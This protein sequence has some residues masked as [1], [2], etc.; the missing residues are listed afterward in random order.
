MSPT[1]PHC[2]TLPGGPT[3]LLLEAHDEPVV[4]FQ[5]WAGVG[6]ADERDSERG[7]AH[8][9]EHMLFKGTDRRGVGELAGDVEGAGGRINA[10]T[11]FDVTVYHT[12]LPSDRA[13]VGVDV[14]CDA[15]LHSRFDADELG[16][17]IEVVLEE[18]RRSQD[19][20]G[21]VLSDALFSHTYEVHPYR[22]PILGSNDSVASFHRDQVRAFYQ[23]WYTPD[24]LTVVATGD[25]DSAQLTARVREAFA[26]VQGSGA[27][28]A[29][30]HEPAQRKLRSVVLARH[31]ERARVELAYPAVSL[32]HGDAPLLDLLAFVLGMG[33]SSRL[34]QRVKE[35]QALVDHIDASCFTPLDPGI[36]TV[37]IETDPGRAADAIAAAV[38]EVEAVRA[39][40]VSGEELEK[41]R[42]NFLTSE[43]F[44]RESVSGQAHKLGAF[45]VTAGG[46]DTFDRYMESIASATPADLQRVARTYLDTNRLTLGALIPEADASALNDET[47]AAAVVRGVEHS[48]RTFS[49]PQRTSAEGELVSYDLDNGVRLHVLPRRQVPIVAARGA[50][51]GGLLAEESST[52]GI[53][54]FTSSMWLRGTRGRSAAD[55]ARTTESLAVEIDRFC[56]RSSL[57]VTL[58]APS[59]RLDP[60]LDLLSE[61]LIEP[62]FD[63]EELERERRETLAALERRKDRL[64]QRAFLLFAETH[65]Q[66]HPYRYPL[67][68]RTETVEGFDVAQV[69]A[70]HQRLVQ[71]EN[72]VMAVAGDVDPD[73][74]ARR[75][76]IR[77]AELPSG[78]FVAPEPALE[79]PP[80]EVRNAEIQMDREQSHLVIGFRGLTVRDDDRVSLELISQLL[81]GQGGRLFLELRDKRSLAYTVSAMNVEGLAPGYFAVYIATAPE[82]FEEA[83]KGLLEE[84]EGLLAKPPAHDELEHAKR[85]LVGNFA[86]DLQRN[87]AHTA[88]LAID[89]L[90]GLGPS[91]YRKFTDEVAAI[92]PEDIA[93]VARRVIDLNAYT[94]AVVRP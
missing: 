47:A 69:R 13:D 22:E 91:A 25:F 66:Q 10:Y 83:R 56:G 44:E 42:T 20:P 93:R 34:V 51:L 24:N 57:G 17:E 30:P 52:S 36:F 70:H 58:E 8:F 73:D 55:F 61:V 63:G 46:Y 7:L 39:E 59:E 50:M 29:R 19:S 86:I 79:E 92:T 40:P 75:L 37:G 28:R 21:H 35:R 27:Q 14:L 90:Y 16:R 38:R 48:A 33:D 45:Q 43:H 12:T 94:M 72:L 11:S 78:G 62:A 81:T 26:G 31:F 65:Y 60:A 4:E 53:T 68:G 64:A 77:L 32:A 2:E 74:M 49:I 23:R 89:G 67:L 80:S 87:A 76:S 3:L 85:Y 41:A 15:V 88:H 84:L 6:S 18:I 9:H 1:T 82:K 5:I 71:A 54:S